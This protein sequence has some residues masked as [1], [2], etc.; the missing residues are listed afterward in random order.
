MNI[1]NKQVEDIVKEWFTKTVRDEWRRLRRDPYHQIEFLVTRHFLEKYLPKRGL[2]LD[3]GGGPGR[4]TIELAKRGYNIVLLDLAPEMLKLAKKKIKRA[5]VQGR[6]KQ[7]IEGSITD[8]SV[9]AD[10]SFDAVLCL[11]APLCHILNAKQREKAA[12]ELVRVAKVDAPVFVSVI[13]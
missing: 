9:F 12:G 2:V 6:I 3:A 10:D 13:S 11:G 7:I 4:Y 8:L 5:G 1:N